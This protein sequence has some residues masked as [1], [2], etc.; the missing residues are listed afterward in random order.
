MPGEVV[1]ARGDRQG[2][3]RA[4]WFAARGVTCFVLRYRQPYDGWAAGREAPLQDAQR[5]MRVIRAHATHWGVDAARVMV[6]GF[7]AGGHIA[8]VAGDP[9]RPPLAPGVDATD[10]LDA[11]PAL[12]ALIYPV[13]TMGA[14]ASMQTRGFLLGD[15]PDAAS[16]E[17]F[18]SSATRMRE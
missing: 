5:A 4:R 3:L 12:T 8:G 2:R 7:S 16:I 15:A 13:I 17:R 9:L 11:Q 6:L 10:A 18:R 1:P 14:A